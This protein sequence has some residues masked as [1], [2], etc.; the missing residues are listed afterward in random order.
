MCSHCTSV[1]YKKNFNCPHPQCASKV[2]PKGGRQGI[3]NIKRMNEDVNQD[4]IDMLKF[5]CVNINKS[6]TFTGSLKEMIDH[7]KKCEKRMQKNY[8]EESSGKGGESDMEMDSLPDLSIVF[9]ESKNMKKID[10]I[11]TNAGDK[12]NIP[13]HKNENGNC[14]RKLSKCNNKKSKKQSIN[15]AGNNNDKV[16]KTEIAK[17]P[18]KNKSQNNENEQVKLV[19]TPQIVKKNFSIDENMQNE[20][21]STKKGRH[22]QMKDDF[23]EDHTPNPE[24]EDKKLGKNS[25]N[26]S[27]SNNLHKPEYNQGTENLSTTIQKSVSNSSTLEQPRETNTT[28]I[29][30]KTLVNNKF[31]K[32]IEKMITK[33]SK[34]ES[35]NRKMSKKNSPQKDFNHEN[36]FNS[37]KTKLMQPESNSITCNKLNG[38]ISTTQTLE[39][40]KTD[41]SKSFFLKNTNTSYNTSTEESSLIL[42]S[43]NSSLVTAISAGNINENKSHE[44]GDSSTSK[45]SSIE[46]QNDSDS[47]NVQQWSMTCIEDE[48]DHTE[49]INK[50]KKYSQVGVSCDPSVVDALM[51]FCEKR[52]ND[53][54]EAVFKIMKEFTNENKVSNEVLRNFSL[55]ITLSWKEPEIITLDD[56]DEDNDDDND[57]DDDNNKDDDN[58]SSSNAI[59]ESNVVRDMHKQSSHLVNEVEKSNSDSS[60]DISPVS[61]NKRKHNQDIQN[62]GAEKKLKKGENSHSTIRNITEASQLL[63]TNPIIKNSQHLINNISNLTLNSSTNEVNSK[64]ITNSTLNLSPLKQTVGGKS[65]STF[66]SSNSISK[67]MPKNILLDKD[68]AIASN[69]SQTNELTDSEPNRVFQK[70]C[71]GTNSNL[72]STSSLS[73]SRTKNI[74]LDNGIAIATKLTNESADCESSRFITLANSSNTSFEVIYPTEL[75]AQVKDSHRPLLIQSPKI[76]ESENTL[77]TKSGNKTVSVPTGIVLLYPNSKRVSLNE[78]ITFNTETVKRILNQNKQVEYEEKS[79]NLLMDNISVIKNYEH[80][81]VPYQLVK[82][83]KVSEGSLI[84]SE[85]NEPEI[86]SIRITSVKSLTTDTPVSNMTESASL[87]EKTMYKC[88]ICKKQYKIKKNLLKHIETHPKKIG[89]K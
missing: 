9:D 80:E 7:H 61:P 78:N 41:N 38:S 31:N 34:R 65:Y 19:N 28:S 63:D 64:N 58:Q 67:I 69:S 21:I 54:K 47:S 70:N 79:K 36:N 85:G 37:E 17:S 52:K 35:N 5:K 86:R 1:I 6:C 30:Q 68:K 60:I 12:D 51:A 56:D 81:G 23:A 32:V 42:E 16:E 11:S 73:K 62:C 76:S 59:S 24:Q 88:H 57:D 3:R 74:Q 8:E 75:D 84:L 87:I 77:S 4:I 18:S 44:A 45:S 50:R 20:N 82:K 72:D 39:H 46:K 26:E 71:S 25:Q 2:F 29:N 13:I 22:G 14:N 33:K 53:M 89:I 43:N 40:Q 66:I 48:K 15:K 27:K 55:D 10:R 83:K 49:S